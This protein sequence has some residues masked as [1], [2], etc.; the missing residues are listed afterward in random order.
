[1]KKFEKL[2]KNEMKS[3][4]GGQAQYCLLIGSPCTE[5][6]QCCSGPCVVFHNSPTGFVCG[7]S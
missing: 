7:S 1:M 2:S 3:I 4:K 5:N 6:L